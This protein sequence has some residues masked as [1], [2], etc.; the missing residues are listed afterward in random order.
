MQNLS[1]ANGKKGISIT[2]MKTTNEKGRYT[3]AL[4]Y[5]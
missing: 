5:K 3:P 2:L 4:G 1:H